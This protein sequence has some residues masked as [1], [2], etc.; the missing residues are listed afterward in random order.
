MPTFE[1]EFRKIE[2][3]LQRW[4]SL[5][6]L[7]KKIEVRGAGHFVLEGPNIIV[8]NHCGSFKDIAVLFR[9]VPR[10]IFFTANRQIFTQEEFDALIRKYLARHFGELG[11]AANSMLRPIKTAMV[12]FVSSNI[13]KVGTIPVDLAAGRESTRLQISRYLEKGRA[14]IALQGRG[15]VQLKAPHPYISRFQPGTPAI[16]YALYQEAEISVP[17]T[18]LAIQGSHQPWGVPGTIRVNVGEAMHIREFVGGP[19]RDIVERFRRALEVRVRALFLELLR[20]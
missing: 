20:D 16:A 4:L 12:R 7:G 19:A 2:P 8:G 10:H 15:H 14:V 5:L 9:S 18:P 13:Q 6:L 1:D 17:V 11:V 3:T